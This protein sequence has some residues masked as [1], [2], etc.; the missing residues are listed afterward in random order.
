[1][2]RSA[3][4]SSSDAPTATSL[5]E[6]L[7]AHADLL[8]VYTDTDAVVADLREAADV[9]E[10]GQWWRNAPPPMGSAGICGAHGAYVGRSCPKCVTQVRHA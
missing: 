3:R 8:G 7:R 2:T 4:P 5:H 9:I 1:M 6:R 10:R